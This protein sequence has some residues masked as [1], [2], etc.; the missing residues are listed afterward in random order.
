MLYDGIFEFLQR[1]NIVGNVVNRLPLIGPIRQSFVREFKKA[2]DGTVGEQ[3]KTFLSTYNRIAIQ[4]L[5]DFIL[6]NDNR[7]NLAKA[8][9]NVIESIIKRPINQLI[10]ITNT[11]LKL[12]LKANI[13]ASII[14]ISKSPSDFYPII[15]TFYVTYGTRQ[16]SFLTDTLSKVPVRSVA[17]K[18]YIV[19]MLSYI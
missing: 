4:R 8:N 14:T 10:P 16:L 1:I 2:I 13:W 11:E 3:L 7:K 9:R 17:C 6:S 12:K 5:I 19:Y 18:M 15:S